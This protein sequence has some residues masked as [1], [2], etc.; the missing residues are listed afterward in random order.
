[1]CW[2][3]GFSVEEEHP[4]PAKYG[5]VHWGCRVCWIFTIG[6][7]DI[8]KR[9]III[10]NPFF[11]WRG[12]FD[13]SE[14]GPCFGGF[15]SP[16]KNRGQ[17]GSGSG[18]ICRF[19]SGELCWSSRIQCLWSPGDFQLWKLE[20]GYF[21]ESKI[22]TSFGDIIIMLD[23]MKVS[24]IC[25][26]G[27]STR[28]KAWYALINCIIYGSRCQRWTFPGFLRWLFS[29][30]TTGRLPEGLQGLERSDISSCKNCK[31]NH[32]IFYVFFWRG[33]SKIHT[34]QICLF[35]TT[36]FGRESI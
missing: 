6:N 17:R 11:T 35:P 26:W 13:W 12:C 10:W 4:L 5:S 3:C 8:I 14:F 25:I 9:Y 15:F 1:M 18:G 27:H 28:S 20:G 32:L 7:G 33:I 16:P 19:S 21:L 29:K 34:R 24:H 23:Y 31:E 22:R 30:A 36:F 2:A